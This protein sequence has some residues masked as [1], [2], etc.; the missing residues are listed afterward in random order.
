[1]K[2]TKLQKQNLARLINLSFDNHQL[3]QKHIKVIVNHLFKLPRYE[4]IIM[5]KQYLSL[6][7]RRLSNTTA[8]ITSFTELTSLQ[9][10]HL[11]K[12]LSRKYNLT[13]VIFTQD[14]SLLGGVQV[15]IGDA[16][17]ENSLRSKIEQIAQAIRQ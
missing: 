13:E 1:M 17:I 9:K 3:N 16:I 2:L 4:A 6:L 5:L 10:N 12:I 8:Q 14:S 7:K 11:H 15:K